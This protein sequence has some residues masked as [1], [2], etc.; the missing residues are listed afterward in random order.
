MKRSSRPSSTWPGRCRRAASGV[1][2]DAYY[3]AFSAIATESIPARK[4]I[5]VRVEKSGSPKNK[6]GGPMGEYEPGLSVEKIK[7]MGADAVKLLAPFEP[8][9]V[10]SAEHN[11]AFIEQVA[12]DCRRHDILFLLEP[13]AFH[14]QRREEDGQELPSSARPRRRS[15]RLA[16]S[17]ATATST[18]R[19]SPAPSATSPTAS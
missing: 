15:S 8:N 17:A 9:E 18:R 19:S 2:I 4:G 16:S 10:I 11:L 14:L 1:L 6:L 7:L 5:L 12:D 13:V 3:G